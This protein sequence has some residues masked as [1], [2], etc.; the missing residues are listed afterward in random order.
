MSSTSNTA[1]NKKTVVRVIEETGFAYSLSCE[2]GY[3]DADYAEFASAQAL[4]SFQKALKDP[5][6]TYEDLCKLLRRASSREA[7]RRCKTPWHVFMANYLQRHCNANTDKA[8][9]VN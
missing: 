1:V 3:G 5:H 4:R 8:G 7:I 6:L 2:S 9:S